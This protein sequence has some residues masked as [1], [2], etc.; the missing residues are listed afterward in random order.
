MNILF[1]NTT[2]ANPYNVAENLAAVSG[3]MVS[4][5]HVRQMD[6]GKTSF[7]SRYD[8]YEAYDKSLIEFNNL[9]RN[10]MMTADYR[11]IDKIQE[12]KNYRS[13]VFGITFVISLILVILIF[14]SIDFAYTYPAVIAAAAICTGITSLITGIAVRAKYGVNVPDS[15]APIKIKYRFT[16]E[17]ILMSSD[18]DNKMMRYERIRIAENNEIYFINFEGEKYEMS[19]QGFNC[20]LQIFQKLMEE[21]GVRIETYIGQF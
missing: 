4:M 10:A 9:R 19:K 15:N 8:R 14:F 11:K 13:A 12:Y 1:E 2:I 20:P 21:K 7:K 17:Y 16:P 5:N 3:S 18:T 6:D